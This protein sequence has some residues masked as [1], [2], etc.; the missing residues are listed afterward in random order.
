MV[1]GLVVMVHLACTY[2]NIGS[3]YYFEKRDIGIISTLVFGIFQSF[4]QAYFMGFMFLLAGF[5]VPAAYDKKGFGKFIKDRA[6]RLGIPA[7]IYMLIIQ[8]FIC[9][10]ILGDYYRINR[11]LFLK[12][13]LQKIMT[14]DFLGGSGPL[15]FVFALLIFCMIYA[16]VR[17]LSK[18][19]VTNGEKPFPSA[20]SIFIL[21]GIMGGVTFLVRIIQ[22]IGT[23]VMNMQLCFFTQYIMLFVIGIKA[24][25]YNWLEQINYSW[26][27]KWL[28]AAVIAGPLILIGIFVGTGAASSGVDGFNSAMGG[29]H[30]ASLV[31]SIWESFI[32]VAM[33]IGLIALFKEKFNKPN[34]LFQAL[35]DNGFAVYMFH[36]PIIIYLSFLFRDINL[37]AFS[38]FILMCVIDLPVCFLAAH[39]IFRKIPLL[40]KIL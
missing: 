40:K 9:Y 8:P 34:R 20:K 15:W 3:W 16:F 23:T 35:S 25:R 5:F 33:A 24:Y 32:A 26:G 17:R 14:L 4:T 12:D 30:I 39:F 27:I 11:A 22:P 13:S 21:I 29:L 36:A 38:K 37:P 6:I 10:V 19:R 7:L 2:S 31:Y 18:N 28:K 1:I